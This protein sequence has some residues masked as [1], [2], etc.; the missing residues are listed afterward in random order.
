MVRTVYAS[1]TQTYVGASSWTPVDMIS[2]AIS[3]I[4]RDQGPGHET[5]ITGIEFGRPVGWLISECRT[6][7]TKECASESDQEHYR[8]W[9][10]DFI[11]AGEY[12]TVYDDGTE[13]PACCQRVR[14]AYAGERTYEVE[15]DRS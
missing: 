14:V 9:I 11:D 1:G 3:G 6:H 4:L 7:G 2:Y 5:V 13:S 10:Q 15:T 12:G 8:A